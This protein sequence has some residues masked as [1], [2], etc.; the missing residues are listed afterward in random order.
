MLVTFKLCF[1]QWL[2]FSYFKLC[3][4]VGWLVGGANVNWLIFSIC[5]SPTSHHPLFSQLFKYQ[6]KYSCIY[7]I[8]V[9][10][11]PSTCILDAT[12]SLFPF[13]LLTSNVFFFLSPQICLLH[14]LS[15]T[16]ISISFLFSSPFSFLLLS[17]FTCWNVFWHSAPVCL[18]LPFPEGLYQ[19]RLPQTYF[20]ASEK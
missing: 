11:D 13:I 8:V 20:L 6:V 2:T 3:W 19:I 1:F 7:L 5:P 12:E 9:L 15:F 14:F 18:Y 4:L 17:S 16:W 10:Q